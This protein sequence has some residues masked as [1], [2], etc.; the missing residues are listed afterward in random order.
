MAPISALHPL[1]K[2]MHNTASMSIDEFIEA[3]L[4]EDIG[5]GDHTS[6]AC[7]P[8]TATGTAQLLVKEPGVL[9]GMDVAERVFAKVDG[10][11]QVQRLLNDGA[12][13]QPGDIAFK[14][15][16]PSRSILTAERLV[17]N[18]MQRMSGIAT[19]TN[20]IMKRLEGL[21]TQVLDTR[22]TTPNLRMF[23]KW[24]V[25]IGGGTN[26]RIGLYDMMMIK[27]NH[28][29]YAGGIREAI[30]AAQNYQRTKGKSLKIEVEARN[31]DEVQQIL[32]VGGV[33]RIMLD[34]FD[35]DTTR[36]AVALIDGR[37]ETESSGGITL[38]TIREYAE[39][40][41]DFI[42]VGA[43]THSVKSLDL[44]LKAVD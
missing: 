16:G 22:K 18:L 33:H 35:Y 40:G 3:A 36:E 12:Q 31:I 44:S 43:L 26:H 42:S 14:V 13:V 11:L 9:A 20:T 41:V 8:D 30:E 5:D 4:A 7:I 28:I 34:N 37:A 29:D 10:R 27:D 24:A 15:S 6:Q 21:K 19:Q 25:R 39:C 17:L 2:H 1:P 38:E 23:E 32:A